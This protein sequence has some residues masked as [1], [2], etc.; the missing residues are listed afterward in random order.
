MMTPRNPPTARQARLGAELRK[1]RDAA[2]ISAREASELLHIHPVS[3]SQLESGKIGISAERVRR[4]AANYACADEK[5]IDAL[6]AMAEERTRGWWEEYR[7]VLPA[8]SLDLAEMEHHATFLRNVQIVHVPGLL[9]TQDYA[10]AVFSYTLPELPRNELEPRV[11]H[12]MQ[13]KVVIDRYPPT[14]LIAIVH[15]AALRIQVADS[16][17]SLTQLRTLLDQ[18]EREHVT[19]RVIPFSREG[20][21]G[22]N[23]SM[24]HAG[25]SAPQLDTVLQDSPQGGSFIHAQAQISRLS[26]LFRKVE[27]ASL[28]TVASRDLIHRIARE[29]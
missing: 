7:G 16:K 22:A 26:S 8:V 14:E 6:A 23:S 12:R 28:D 9:Q 15:E 5:L 3:I 21:A 4:L 11:A 19:L 17:A 29:L 2:G 13:R 25:G 27:Q 1:L 18:S 10:R 24:L 20:F